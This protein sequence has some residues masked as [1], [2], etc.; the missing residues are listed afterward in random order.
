MRSSRMSMV[1]AAMAALSSAAFSQGATVESPPQPKLRDAF[2][3]MR[4]NTTPS[5]NKRPAG[6]NMAFIR[7]ARKLRNKAK[8]KR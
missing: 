5:A 7:R 2:N 3:P 6:A 8:A 4:V 1:A